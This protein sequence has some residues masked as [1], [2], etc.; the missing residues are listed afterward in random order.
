VQEKTRAARHARSAERPLWAATGASLGLLLF[1]W[2]MLRGHHH[3]R[4][5]VDAMDG[6][7]VFA[8]AIA[9]IGGG[10]LPFAWAGRRLEAAWAAREKKQ[11]DRQAK[12]VDD[13]SSHFQVYQGGAASAS[14][15]TNRRRLDELAGQ[16]TVIAAEARATKMTYDGVIGALGGYLAEHGYQVGDDLQPTTVMR[17]APYLVTKDGEVVGGDEKNSA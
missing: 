8:L 1:S 10:W 2:V 14:S 13:L 6:L 5:E 15:E 16:L 3:P 4:G 12:K 7:R 9:C 17:P 11:E